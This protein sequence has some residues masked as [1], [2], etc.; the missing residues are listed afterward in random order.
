MKRFLSIILAI[1]LLIASGCGSTSGNNEQ[2]DN[3]PTNNEQNAGTANTPND[4]STGETQDDTAGTG[5]ESPEPDTTVS[6][7]SDY[8]PVNTGWKLGDTIADFTITTF[9]K[10]TVTLSE[11]L[12]E[13]DA[14]LI[15]IF[16]T[17]CGPCKSEFPFMESTYKQMKDSVEIIALSGDSSDTTELV[18]QLATSLGLTFPMGLDSAGISRGIK[19]TAYPTTLVVDRFGTIVFFQIGSFPDES[20]FF[21]LFDF[22][23]SDEYTE[24]VVLKELPPVMP[25]LD[26][27]SSEELSAALSDNSIVFDN[28]P[29]Q[30]N[31]PMALA[32]IDGRN[33]LV[34]SNKGTDESRSAVQT[35]INAVAGNVFAFDLKL[36]SESGFDFFT[37]SVNDEIVKVF[38][39]EKDWSSYAYEFTADGEYVVELAFVKDEAEGH[40][41]DSLWLDNVRL[42][43]GDEA[44]AAL[45]ANTRY[46]SAAE[47]SFTIT[48]ENVTRVVFDDPYKIVYKIFGCD[49]QAYLLNSLEANCVFTLAGNVDPDAAICF[50]NNKNRYVMPSLLSGN[51][52]SATFTVDS[53]GTT[54][55]AY[56]SV[57]LDPNINVEGDEF[58]VFFFAD[59]EGLNKFVKTF[60]AG[61]W[62]DAE[63]WEQEN[64]TEEPQGDVVYTFRCVDENGER[65]SG[66]TLQ[67]CN[68]S[69]CSVYV[70]NENGE[71]VVTLPCDNY[72]IHILKAPDGYTFDSEAVFDA[73]IE[74]GEVTITLKRA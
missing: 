11:V 3:T 65:I 48:N 5:E 68:D 55:K 26:K 27:L 47:T 69:T 36:A 54:G 25:H 34:S 41:E 22:L 38:S 43:S 70:T 28:V 6:G 7:D 58:P 72:E 16:A 1:T 45:A 8:N 40:G 33:V 20:S 52:Y 46:P 12:A 66:V 39:G 50:D 17:W 61:A 24:S 56:T 10:K 15:N 64:Q 4:E 60:A 44:A 19:L 9:D 57:V 30:Y 73:P 23:V 37:L 13:K 18:R 63:E 53:I 59:E 49:Y 71:C 21:R 14:V 31:W 35:T 51:G 74:G 62:H 29:G 67:V 2:P 42:L 32:E